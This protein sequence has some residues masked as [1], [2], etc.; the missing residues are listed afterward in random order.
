MEIKNGIKRA[1]PLEAVLLFCCIWIRLQVSG[2][3]E[4]EDKLSSYPFRTDHINVFS[5]G[6][7]DFL[8]N[9]KSQAGSLFVF[10]P[11][12]VGFVKTFPDFFD[13]VFVSLYISRTFFAVKKIR[14]Y[15]DFN[16]H[17]FNMKVISSQKNY[18]NINEF[19]KI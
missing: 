8:Y 4:T 5:M 16:Q 1:E 10:A 3:W 2:F 13:A 17:K 15:L 19:E 14:N 18:T 9:G 11:G 7:Y 6:L 12:Q